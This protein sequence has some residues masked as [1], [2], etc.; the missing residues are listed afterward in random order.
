LTV[1]EEFKLPFSAEY[2]LWGA[3]SHNELL[4]RVLES[5][6]KASSSIATDHTGLEIDARVEEGDPAKVIC[7]V[8]VNE[9][10][11]LIVIGY[12]GHGLVENLVLGSVSRHVADQSQV[13][14]LIVK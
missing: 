6:N 14:V 8:A 12:K 4:R 11:N 2:G 7:E 3:E 9:G 5:L 13:P 10:F 1:I